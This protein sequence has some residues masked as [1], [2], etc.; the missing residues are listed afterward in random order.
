MIESS[1]QLAWTNLIIS[2]TETVGPKN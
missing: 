1:E 2:W